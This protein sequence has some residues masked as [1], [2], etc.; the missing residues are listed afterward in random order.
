MESN[1]NDHSNEPQAAATSKPEK[2]LVRSTFKRAIWLFSSF[3]LESI[4]RLVVV[5]ILA[6][7]VTPEAFGIVAAAMAVLAIAETIAKLGINAAVIQHPTLDSQHIR[8]SVMLALTLGTV[9]GLG[10]WLLSP[11]LESFFEMPA[12]GPVLTAFAVALPFRNLMYIWQAMMERYLRF[13]ALACLELVS[14]LFGYA[15]LSILLASQGFGAWALIGGILGQMALRLLLMVIMQRLPVWPIF[16]RKPYQDLLTFGAGQTAGSFA[17][18]GASIGDRLVVGHTMGAATLGIYDRAVQLMLTPTRVMGEVGDRVL[19]ATMSGMQRDVERLRSAYLKS[20]SL[21]CLVSMPLS[22]LLF[23]W[24][25]WI[26]LLLLGPEWT[27]AIVPFRILTLVMSLR[28][29]TRLNDSLTRAS[30]AVFRRAWRQAF[31]A[32]LI[33]GGCWL[34]HP[35]DLKGVTAAVCLAVLVNFMMMTNLS[36]RVLGLGWSRLALSLVPGLA[37]S[38]LAALIFLLF[39]AMGDIAQS[40]MLI[41]YLLALIT[42][43]PATLCAWW[44]AP[45]LFLGEGGK[46]ILDVIWNKLPISFTRK[47]A[48]LFARVGEP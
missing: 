5:A 39:V 7:L 47:Y 13:S 11:L 26:I 3:G 2:D 21:I 15:G 41:N 4:L 22:V 10:I 48:K 6:R 44:L 16:T 8:A 20:A 23:I 31:Y 28:V 9:V 1:E 18:M 36:L 12:L 19:Y 17:N 14:Y 38:A 40:S 42:F 46:A 43:V 30:G 32:V 24:A 29:L 34:A 33:I 35:F 37:V 25:P 45:D 27:Q